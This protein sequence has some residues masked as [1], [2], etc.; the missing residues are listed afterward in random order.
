LQFYLKL[1][2]KH[3]AMEE[4]KIQL[5]AKMKVISL[6]V[7]DFPLSCI[8]VLLCLCFKPSYIF[9]MKNLVLN[10]S[11]MQ[12]QCFCFRSSCN[13][14]TVAVSNFVPTIFYDCNMLPDSQPVPAENK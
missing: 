12:L 10:M 4:E 1:E 6:A 14:Y 2:E 7:I 3:Q 5:E 9:T 13:V 8:C 11:I